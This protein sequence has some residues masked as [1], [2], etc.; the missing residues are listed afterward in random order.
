MSAT[1][2]DIVV[3]NP[4]KGRKK[5]EALRRKNPHLT[6]V[7]IEKMTAEDVAALLAR[8]KLYIDFG[9]HPGKDR[10]PREAAIAGCCVVT[11]QRGAAA[12]HEDLPIPGLYKLQDR[13]KTYIEQF[14]SLAMDIFERFSYHSSH[15]ESYRALIRREPEIFFEQVRGIFGNRRSDVFMRNEHRNF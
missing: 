15:F 9:R 5:T 8:A 10:L 7:P 13:R 3:F 14:P 4:K 2:E 6:F 1:R 11:G 12:C